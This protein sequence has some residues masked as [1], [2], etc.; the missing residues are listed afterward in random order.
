MDYYYGDA[1]V[2]DRVLTKDLILKRG[3]DFGVTEQLFSRVSSG[4]S[5]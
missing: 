3:L 5:A 2:M 4:G 1:Q